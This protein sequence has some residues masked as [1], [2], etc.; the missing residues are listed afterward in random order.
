[1]IV[2]ASN[3]YIVFEVKYSE[4]TCLLVGE[5]GVESILTNLAANY[6]KV[7]TF[8]QA[9]EKLEIEIYLA[10]T[11]IPVTHSM[12]LFEE[13]YR[14]FPKTV[15]NRVNNVPKSKVF[16][17]YKK[18]LKKNFTVHEEIMRCL[19]YEID[20]RENKNTLKYMKGIM[21]WLK[22]EQWKNYLNVDGTHN[23]DNWI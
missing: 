14:E 21:N 19:R 20:F 6:H 7:E 17:L 1:M 2:Q 10:A 8:I 3:K 9:L 4:I 13:F 18:I 15:H 11:L 5:R 23:N 12:I 22:T 16:N